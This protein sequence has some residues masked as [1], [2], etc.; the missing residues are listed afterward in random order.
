[1]KLE[2]AEITTETRKKFKEMCDRHTEAFSK[3]NK[4]IGRTTL[5]EMEIDTG[6]SLPVTQNPYMLP[7]KHQEWVHKEIKTLEKAG[8]IERSL[9][10]R[11]VNSL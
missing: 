5:I 10:Y 9:S 4:N 7:L 11:K 1:M 6:D 8:V 2:D 3:N